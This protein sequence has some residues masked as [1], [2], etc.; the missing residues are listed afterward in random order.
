MV[1]WCVLYTVDSCRLCA[2]DRG[3]YSAQ[4]TSVHLSGVYSLQEIPVDSQPTVDPG[5][6]TPEALHCRLFLGVSGFWGVSWGLDSA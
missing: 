3:V 4:C 6:V 5:G 2:V 1:D